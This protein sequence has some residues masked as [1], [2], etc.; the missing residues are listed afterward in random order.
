MHRMFVHFLLSAILI[1]Q[2]VGAV[3]AD[4]PTIPYTTNQSTAASQGMTM[5]AASMEKTCPGCPACP[6]DS[7]PG[8]DCLDN[9]SLPA[10]LPGMPALVRHV[11]SSDALVSVPRVSLVDFA[12]IP[13]TP[14]PIA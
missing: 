7:K 9:C 5:T 6:E 3:C 10:G 4:G 12:Q 2:G 13:P 11:P 1:F 8:S 14:P